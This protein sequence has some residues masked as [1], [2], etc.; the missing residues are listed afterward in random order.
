LFL[1]LLVGS[2]AAAI[3]FFAPIMLPA[4]A[5]ALLAGVHAM[6]QLGDVAQKIHWTQV[7]EAARAAGVDEQK[8]KLWLESRQVSISIKPTLT[9][10]VNK[11][12]GDP[13]RKEEETATPT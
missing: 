10:T 7:A 6:G 12:T 8:A 2:F 11:K 13:H 9:V 4:V 1:G 5:P 3:A